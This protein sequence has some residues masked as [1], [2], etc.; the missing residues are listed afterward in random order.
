MSGLIEGEEQLADRE[1]IA[2]TGLISALRSARRDG[3][4]HELAMEAVAARAVGP[5]DLEDEV[6]PLLHDGGAGV[7]VEGMLEDDQIMV[8]KQSLLMG[9]IDREMRILGVEIANGDALEAADGCDHGPLDERR[10][11]ARMREEDEDFHRRAFMPRAG[12]KASGSNGD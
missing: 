4:H 5:A 8:R 9:H 3:G 1:A 12:A 10:R 6:E 11:Q 7:P 2:A